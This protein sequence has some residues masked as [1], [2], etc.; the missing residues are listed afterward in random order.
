VRDGTGDADLDRG[1]GLVGL[2][3]RVEA[4]GGRI[5]VDCPHGTGTTCVRSYRSPP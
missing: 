3:D 5:L 1:I 2:E 4:L